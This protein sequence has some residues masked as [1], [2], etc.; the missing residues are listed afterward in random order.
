M[1]FKFHHCR[2]LDIEDTQEIILLLL[3]NRDIFLAFPLLLSGLGTGITEYLMM[4][5]LNALYH[6]RVLVSSIECVPRK[7]SDDSN[8]AVHLGFQSY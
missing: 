5:A 6:Q 7:E 2:L 1:R 3:N 4:V 8:L